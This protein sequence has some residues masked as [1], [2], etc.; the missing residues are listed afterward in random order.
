VSL[1]KRATS[2]LEWPVHAVRSDVGEAV[3]VARAAAAYRHVSP[4]LAESREP[5]I[6]GDGWP[7][8][9]ALVHGAGHNGSAWGTWEPRLRAA[10][11]RRLVA[12]E[13]KA[14]AQSMTAL[15]SDLGQRLERICER[16]GSD[17]V[18]VIGH[19]L[20]G[21]ALRVWHDLMDGAPILGA[22][23]TL[24][25]PHQGL[26]W[27]RLPGTPPT[28]RDLGSGSWLHRELQHWSAEHTRWTTIAGARDR[29]VPP[30]FAGLDG[31][32]T[33]TLRHLGHMGLLYS[34][35]VAGQAT[36]ELL[37]VEEATRAWAS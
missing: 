20:G 12:L 8:P 17:R 23:V 30:R 2:V 34:R 33:S 21:F 11:F 19:S 5:W 10:G 22:A 32:P 31:P 26:P 27:A 37:A 13:Y 9:V 1:W 28:L 25:S 3:S 4:E 18:H 6:D 36:V 16:A 14:A 7:T 24:G 35:T 15:A 29:L